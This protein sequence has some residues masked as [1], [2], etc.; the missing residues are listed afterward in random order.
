MTIIETIESELCRL[1]ICIDEFPEAPADYDDLG[2]M[3]CFHSRYDLGDNHDYSLAEVQA[4][5]KNKEYLT[6][7]IYMYEHSGIALSSSSFSCPWD[8]GRLGLF[9]I[10]K[11]EARS[12][13]GVRRL[14]KKCEESILSRW[15]SKIDYTNAYLNGSV[16]GYEAIDNSEDV[17]ASCWSYWGS[18]ARTQ[19]IDDATFELK[20]VFGVDEIIWS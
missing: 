18:E 12:Y 6:L 5:E 19:M 11:E 20:H 2:V 1:N 7:P 10:K 4:I 16:Y 15:Q 14:T 13:F 8:S 17:V 9:F 3:A